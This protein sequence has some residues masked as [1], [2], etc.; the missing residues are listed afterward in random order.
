[1]QAL[2]NLDELPNMLLGC[3]M[4]RVHDWGQS[5][6]RAHLSPKQEALPGWWVL[7]SL[8]CWRRMGRV[9]VNAIIY[10]TTSRVLRYVQ[11]IRDYPYNRL[12]AVVGLHL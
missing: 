8:A 12:A 10:L 1:M 3:C 5:M 9:A 7:M 4:T 2:E 6:W 11:P